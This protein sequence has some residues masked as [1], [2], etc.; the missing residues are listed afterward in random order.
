MSAKRTLIVIGGPT[1]SGKTKAAVAIAQHFGTEVISAD[2]RQFY[3]AMRIGTARPSTDELHGVPHHFIGHLDL[4]G[5][6]SAGQFARS[7]EPILQALMD[8]YGIAVLVGGSGL[9][10]DALTKGLDPL[11][12]TDPRLRERLQKRIDRNGID[13]LLAELATLDPATHARI[14]KHNPHRVIRALEVCLITGKPFSAQRSSPSDRTD[15]RIIRI[16]LDLPR[17]ELYKRI[18][19]RVDRMIADGL[20]A[21]ARD[22]LPFRDAN[23]LRTVGYRELFEHF[24]GSI[25]LPGAIASIKQHTRNYAKRQQTWW[26]RDPSWVRFSPTELAGMIAAIEQELRKDQA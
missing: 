6:W 24:D 26:R 5:M 23:A 15:I 17:A 4:S 1:A 11:P 7:A 2:S 8:Q 25:D 13:D 21:E 16:A 3:G 18:D 22:L 12:A 20:V 9:Y 19:D 14:D 10:I